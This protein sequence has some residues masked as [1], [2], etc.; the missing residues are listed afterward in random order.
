MHCTYNYYEFIFVYSY[1][2]WSHTASIGYALLFLQWMQL[3]MP[4]YNIVFFYQISIVNR[5]LNACSSV[6]F[7]DRKWLN[8]VDHWRAESWKNNIVNTVWN[9]PIG[10]HV[11]GTYPQYLKSMRSKII[12]EEPQTAWPSESSRPRRQGMHLSPSAALYDLIFYIFVT[13]TRLK[14]RTT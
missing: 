13:S 9:V 1:C 5:R 8:D 14:R 4:T 7:T 12:R 10:T 2:H 3:L 11:N 6:I